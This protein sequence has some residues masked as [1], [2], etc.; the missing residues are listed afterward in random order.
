MPRKPSNFCRYVCVFYLLFSA[1]RLAAQSPLSIYTDHLV[2]GFQDWG[3]GTKNVT[4]TTPVHS[5]TASFSHSGGA[6]N[7]LSFEHSDFNATLY[8]GLS[9]WANG[10]VGGGQIVN[11]TAAFGTTDPAALPVVIQLPTNTWQQFVIPLDTLGISG[12]TDVN[13]FTFQLTDSGSTAG[14]FVDDI[15][16]QSAPPPTI[17]HLAVDAAQKMRTADARWSGLNT[18]T[19]DSVLA[20]PAT[21]SVL[22]EMGCRTLRWPGGSTSDTYHWASDTAGY[23]RFN[24][25][26]SNLNAQAFITVNYGSGSVNEAAAW[27]KSLNVTNH[28]GYKY[29]EI[30]NEN[31]GSWE[32]DTNVPAHDP[33]T[34]AN[35]TKSYITAMKAADPTIKIGV[36]VTTGEDSY[37]NNTTHPAVN[38]RTGQTHN[39]W[40]PVLLSTLKAIGVTPDFAVYHSYPQYTPS[41][42]QPNSP[43]SDALLLQ[44]GAQWASDAADLRQQL[45]DYLGS[46]AT[47]I[48]IVCT[49]NNCNS[50]SM[51]RQS[52]SIV[53][54]LFLA[55]SVSQLMK[56]EFNA[57][58]WWDLHNGTDTTGDFDPTLYGWRNNG[59]YG[60]VSTSN[61][62]YPAFYAQKLL[63][64]F[65]APGDTVLGAASD[66]LLLSAYA[67]RKASGALALLVINKTPT[68]ILNGEIALAHFVPWTNTLA[69]SFGIQQDEATRTNGPAAAKDIATNAIVSANLFT[70]S[71]PPYSLTLLTFPPT[72]PTLSL[73]AAAQSPGQMV[74]QI[75]GQPD[76]RVIIQSSTDLAIWTRVSTNLISNGSVMVTNSVVATATPQF[77]RAMWE[78]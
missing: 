27:V 56:T 36:V 76:T 37:A 29:W 72:A 53:N 50:G 26:A 17:V 54:A 45:S 31:Y 67:T 33:F 46:S 22:R 8:T 34:Y 48:E 3:W 32:N 13:R 68:N 66:S 47:N 21:I 20:Q 62:R 70:N 7:A 1:S 10:G 5:G 28:Y 55:D 38:P 64:Y 59:D 75:N 52:T 69:R 4:N 2:N 71:F 51:G 74:V 6:W 39:G 60:I 61:V 49:E 65:V 23:A 58:I 44:V 42:W 12:A 11:V 14:F 73:P 25:V 9:F 35:L 30:G 77:W 19:W 40:T 63:Q 43:E 41:N 24:L 18:A 78:P 16:L 15:Q 57:C